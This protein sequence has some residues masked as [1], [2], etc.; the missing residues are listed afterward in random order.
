MQE[1]GNGLLKFALI[2]IVLSGVNMTKTSLDI[3]Q[4]VPDYLNSFDRFGKS[5]FITFRPAPNRASL[6]AIIGDIFELLFP[7]RSGGQILNEKTVI[8]HIKTLMSRVSDNL[9]HQIFL[10]YFHENPFKLE[11]T[12]TSSYEKIA[13]ET[14]I[15]LLKALPQLRIMMKE[16]AQAAF[17]GDPA[18][19]S[20]QETI[21][22]YPG[23]CALTMHR[24]SHF[25]YEKKVPLIPRMLSEIIHNQTGID[26]HPGATIGRSLFIDH[27]TGVVIGETTII[28]NNVK[29]YQGVTLGSLSFPKDACGSLIRGAK[30]HPSIGD[31]VTIYA[32]ATIL[33]D[34]TIGE[35]TIVGSSAW[36]HKDVPSYSFVQNEPPQAIIRERYG[37]NR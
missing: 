7:G 30:R 26:I 10:G 28:G 2:D 22:T 15:E 25:L 5:S 9:E 27:G 12:D 23:I 18:A 6:K 37:K 24:I 20:V 29:I 34:I 36:I 32:N 16:D 35:H 3:S 4:F 11:E 13:R 8:P 21:L 14:I 31:F 1:R 17:D 33:G 19:T